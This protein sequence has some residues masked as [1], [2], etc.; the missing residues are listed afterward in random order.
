MSNFTKAKSPTESA[1]W[2]FRIN[3]LSQEQLDKLKNIEGVEWIVIGNNEKEDQ[4]GEHYHCAIKFTRS[5]RKSAVL[6]RV[7]LNTNLVNDIDYYLETKYTYSSIDEF[8]DYC[9]K[10]GT[11]HDTYHEIDAP[12]TPPAKTKMSKLE[13]QK[14][15][16]EKARAGAEDWFLENDFDFML[17]SKY[18]K[19]ILLVQPHKTKIL[20]GDLCN[21]W[22]WGPSGT[23]KSFI[24]HYLWPDAYPKVVSNSKWDNY[25]NTNPGHQVVHIEEVDDFDDIKEGLEGLAGLKRIAD[26]YP[27]PVRMN[28]GSRNLMIRPKTIVI[29]SNFSPSQ[30]LSAPDK[31]GKVTRGLETQLKAISRKFKV[32]H[33]SE[34]KKLFGLVDKYDSN[35]KLI[36]VQAPQVY[37]DEDIENIINEGVNELMFDHNLEVDEL[38]EI[39]V[40]SPRLFEPMLIEPRSVRTRKEEKKDNNLMNL[41]DDRYWME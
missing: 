25:S 35:G 13:L 38:T 33:I 9:I 15:R 12:P 39:P 1:Y 40:I 10:N 22:V 26:R 23:C 28:Y 41:E 7:L 34:F 21:Y 8:I 36:G 37:N 16:V 14:L 5:L 18:A 27:F 3:D 31:H 17:G 32:L 24:I 20:D 11:K 30:I 4:K 2:H 19:L 29:T 6:K